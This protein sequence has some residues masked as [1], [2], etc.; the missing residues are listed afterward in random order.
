MR[1]IIFS[2][3]SL[4]VGML[5]LH[6][7]SSNDNPTNEPTVRPDTPSV[8]E[9]DYLSIENAV[10]HEGTFPAATTST[11]ISGLSINQ[12]AL[13]GGMNIITVV[14]DKTYKRF[15]VGVKGVPGYWI[16][17]PE[18]G[19]ATTRAASS[20][21]YTIP[22]MYSPELD[23]NVTML[24]SGED[25]NGDVT[26]PYEAEISFVDSESGE[27]NINLTFSNAKDVDLHLFMP[28]GEHIFYG[29]RGG[30]VQTT[31]GSTV[32]YGLDHDSNAGCT[33]DNLN[34]EN[35]YIPAELIQPGTYRVVV[36][37]YSNCDPSS[38]T[39]WS[40]VT[41]YKGELI[42]T[43]AGANPASGVYPVGAGNG[44]MS[45]A[46]TFTIN[47]GSTTRSAAASRIKANTFVPVPLSD[48]DEMKLE[49]AGYRLK[50]AK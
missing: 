50:F 6:S 39:S 46:M 20:N 18:S 35:I 44:D 13:Q 8:L 31:D 38:A 41:R 34:N 1:K 17:T 24:I 15:F 27:L 7:C 19:N 5:M 3:C 36:D 10:Y 21:T 26:E 12:R 29:A 33:I 42:S 48:M 32:S 16:Y 2:L 28:N 9:T 47:E 49:E 22:V 25:E 4:C 14:T 23:T 11:A 30:S 43:T 40:I 45:T 37:M